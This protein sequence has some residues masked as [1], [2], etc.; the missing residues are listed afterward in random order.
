MQAPVYNLNGEIVSQMEIRDDVFSISPIEKPFGNISE[1]E[2]LVIP[3]NPPLLEGNNVE[4]KY[5]RL[6]VDPFF[7]CCY[8]SGM[9]L[10]YMPPK[11]RI[12]PVG[13]INILRSV[14]GVTLATGVNHYLD[15]TTYPYTSKS[16]ELDW[17]TTEHDKYANILI[18]MI[19][20]RNRELQMVQ[21]KMA[22]GQKNK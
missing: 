10:V 16:V 17:D 20:Y 11:S 18:S 15:G 13:M 7:D 22:E 21:L 1:G 5:L 14:E 4:F 19:S 3:I 2:M 12:V 6:P 9:D 8:T